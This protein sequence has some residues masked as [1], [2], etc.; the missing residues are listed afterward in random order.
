LPQELT[1]TLGY[2]SNTKTSNGQNIS[3]GLHLVLHVVK[4]PVAVDVGTILVNKL[5]DALSLY[6]P[7]HGEKK[8]KKISK[9]SYSHLQRVLRHA[10]DRGLGVEHVLLSRIAQVRVHLC[11]KTVRLKSGNDLTVP[12]LPLASTS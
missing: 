3:S 2:I 11:K 4:L 9:P 12:F 1:V 7:S 8:K 6:H 5:V 10:Q